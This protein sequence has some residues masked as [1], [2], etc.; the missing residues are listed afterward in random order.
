VYKVRKNVD[1]S[2]VMRIRGR[3]KTNGNDCNDV[4]VRVVKRLS[5]DQAHAR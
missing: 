1:V 4:A 3:A 2:V 5:S